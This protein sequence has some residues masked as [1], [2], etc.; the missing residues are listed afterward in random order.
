MN[1]LS[2]LKKD[3]TVQVSFDEDVFGRIE[4][5]G[6]GKNVLLSNKHASAETKTE[7]D[8]EILDYAEPDSSDEEDYDP[9]NSGRFDMS[10]M[11]GSDSHE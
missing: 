7:V 10:K 3:Y 6:P 1:R 4:S 5:G 9:Y 11:W 2:N 8:L